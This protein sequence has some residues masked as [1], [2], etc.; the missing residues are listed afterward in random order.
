MGGLRQGG[1]HKQFLW[2]KKASPRRFFRQQLLIG[3]D[4]CLP[5]CNDLPIGSQCI[6]LTDS[7]GGP[8]PRPW[9]EAP[10]TG[11]KA[12]AAGLLRSRYPQAASRA[13][14]VSCSAC[15]RTGS[16]AHKPT[17]RRLPSHWSHPFVFRADY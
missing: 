11:H 16:A 13:P 14:G 8:P 12:S 9:R 2:L 10:P 1:S 7:H 6:S 15:C 17:E 3:I 5:L 4:T